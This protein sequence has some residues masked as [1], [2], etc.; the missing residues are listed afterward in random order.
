MNW[1]LPGLRRLVGG[2]VLLGAVV[3]STTGCD[4]FFGTDINPERI[5]VKVE[6]ETSADLEL[7]L[8]DRFFLGGVD[9]GDG[10]TT[11]TLISADT[12]LVSPPYDQ[13]FDLAP[14]YQFYVLA[15]ADSMTAPRQIRIQ[16]LVDG[17]SRYDKSGT[18][19]EED[20]EFV[21][22]FN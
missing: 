8:G 3:P 2:A 9:E 14:S 20:F 5:Q 7:V 13:S 4:T 22:N 21:Y 6:S 15:L 17:D 1:F 10:A 12:T 18:L 19:G 11:V 16:V